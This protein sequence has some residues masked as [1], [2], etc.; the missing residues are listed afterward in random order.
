LAAYLEDRY[1]N[2]GFGAQI[3]PYI[4]V[5]TGTSKLMAM[6]VLLMAVWRRHRSNTVVMHSD[7]RGYFRSYDGRDFLDE[8][9]LQQSMDRCRNCHDKAVAENF[10]QLLKQKR[11]RRKPYGPKEDAK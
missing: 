3:I 9:N 6:N 10:F 1:V 4:V 8:H 2:S 11:I 5:R 7:Q